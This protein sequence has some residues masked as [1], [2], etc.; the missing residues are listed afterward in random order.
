MKWDAQGY[1]PLSHLSVCKHP[2]GLGKGVPFPWHGTS[3]ELFCDTKSHF[4]ICHICCPFKASHWEISDNSNLSIVVFCSTYKMRHKQLKGNA[5]GAWHVFKTLWQ[6]WDSSQEPARF[7]FVVFRS[8]LTKKIDI[9]G[10]HLLP[11]LVVKNLL[12]LN[13]TLWEEGG[14]WDWGFVSGGTGIHPLSHIHE[15]TCLS[16]VSI[17]FFSLLKHWMSK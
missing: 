13:L 11:R 2:S 5:L 8:V 12:S 4:N 16:L 17:R 6:V 3:E 14:F 10:E 9:L 15:N 7:W 1:L